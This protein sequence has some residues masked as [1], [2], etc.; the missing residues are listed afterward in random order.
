MADEFLPVG[1][2]LVWFAGWDTVT[3]ACACV[4]RL[5][6]HAPCAIMLFDENNKALACMYI[7]LCCYFVLGRLCVTLYLS[8]HLYCPHWECCSSAACTACA[9]GAV[10]VG[11]T[12]RVQ[13]GDDFWRQTAEMLLCCRMQ[14]RWRGQG[15]NLGP[16]ARVSQVV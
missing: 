11:L 14:Q 9:H 5:H 15:S 7:F 8:S 16:S 2:R 3:I 13:E 10:Q 12:G 6:V 1:L 4:M